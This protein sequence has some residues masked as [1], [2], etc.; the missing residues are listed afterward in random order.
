MKTPHFSAQANGIY[1]MPRRDIVAEGTA[2]RCVAA[3][4]RRA[5]GK[6]AAL[7]AIANAFA[8]P[9]GFGGNWD[10]LNDALQ[11]LS[12]LPVRE[13]G[14]VLRLSGT[15]GFSGAAPEDFALLLEILATAAAYWRGKERVFVVFCDAAGLPQF[16]Q[17]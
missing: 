11:D 7:G 16:P 5:R 8:V 12:W 10:A 17:P 3:D 9:D 2:L 1:R 13:Q 6:K 15:A 4:L 14:I